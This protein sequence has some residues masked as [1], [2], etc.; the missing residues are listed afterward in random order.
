M[1]ALQICFDAASYG[2]ATPL[3]T[4]A[5]ASDLAF[6]HSDLATCLEFLAA[7]LTRRCFLN[8]CVDRPAGGFRV[9]LSGGFVHDHEVWMRDVGIV[10]KSDFHRFGSW[11]FCE[12]RG[13][14]EPALRCAASCCAAETKTARRTNPAGPF[15]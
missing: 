15:P 5:H 2:S 10:K 9:E 1:I 13:R 4:C 8:Q 7:D 3:W 11:W 6:R 14:W 12:Q